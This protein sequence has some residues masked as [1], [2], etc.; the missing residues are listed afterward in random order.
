VAR[1]APRGI[2]GAVAAGTRILSR[3]DKNLVRH[4]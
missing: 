1:F 4:S 3:K 2:C